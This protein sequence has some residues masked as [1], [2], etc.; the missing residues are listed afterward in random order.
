MTDLKKRTELYMSLVFEHSH[1]QSGISSLTLTEPP[2][3]L[4]KSFHQGKLQ[5]DHHI[6][7][8]LTEHGEKDD[9]WG[10]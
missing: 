3:G 1:S 6:Q 2:E 9:E 7:Y 5:V 8:S 4:P 10:G